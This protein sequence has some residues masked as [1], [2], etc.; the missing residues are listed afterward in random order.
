MRTFWNRNISSNNRIRVVGSILIAVFIFL[1][2]A[3]SSETSAI[4]SDLAKWPSEA[5][6]Q[7]QFSGKLRADMTNAKD[8]YFLAALTAP[9]NHKMK[10]RVQQ[11]DV[12]LTYDLLYRTNAK[13]KKKLS[14][15]RVSFRSTEKT[16][17][18]VIVN[19]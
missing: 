12:T 16:T 9:S 8:G 3:W 15:K 14:F 19:K 6:S 17:K 4:A 11:G 13:T 1:I 10:M 18:K 7:L 2:T 5:G